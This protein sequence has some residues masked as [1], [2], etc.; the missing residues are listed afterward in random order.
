MTEQI[1][2]YPNRSVWGEHSTLRRKLERHSVE[3]DV[4]SFC[5]WSKLNEIVAQSGS[6]FNADRNAGFVAAL[7][8]TGGRV[9]EVLALKP[10]MFSV[11]KGCVPKLIV[12]SGMP[13]LKRYKKLSEFLN[14][15]GEKHYKTERINATRDFSFRVDEPLVKPM[16]NWIIHALDNRYEWLFPSPYKMDK[17]L[18]RKWAYQLIKNIGAKTN[19]EIYPHWFRSQRASQFA[20]EYEMT[21]ASILEWFQWTEWATASRYCKL[22]VLGMAKKMGV[23]FRKDRGLKRGDIEKLKM[24]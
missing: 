17:P 1:L 24:E 5:G 13:L 23:K 14:N 18:S 8:S 9:S 10:T 12:I 4:K 3:K 21:E 11:Y 15:K 7:F 20:S 19:M 22:G 6:G 2:A 16:I